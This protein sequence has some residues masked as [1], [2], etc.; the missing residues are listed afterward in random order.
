MEPKTSLMYSNVFVLEKIIFDGDNKFVSLRSAHLEIL[1]LMRK[2]NCNFGKLQRSTPR[3][4]EVRRNLSFDARPF[5]PSSST[6]EG[7]S[8]TP[9]LNDH[10]SSHQQQIGERLYARVCSD[11]YLNQIECQGTMLV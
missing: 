7:S 4:R 3:V 9:G 10:L 5:H 8:N 11:L 2:H 1:Q 6:G